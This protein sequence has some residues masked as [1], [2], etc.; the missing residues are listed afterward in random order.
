[1]K[2]LLII[3][4]AV[5]LIWLAPV[6][7]EAKTFTADGKYTAQ[8]PGG[9]KLQKEQNRFTDTM[10]LE[11]KGDAGVQLENEDIFV[12]TLSGDTDEDMIDS[13]LTTVDSM[14]DNVEEQ[15]RG[16]GKYIINNQTAP[17]LIVTYDQEFTN[18]LGLPADSQEWVAMVI[19]I[20]L[21]NG[22]FVVGQYRN[23]ADDFDD[24][25]PMAEKI[26]KSVEGLGNETKI[27]TE[28]DTFSETGTGTGTDFSKTKALCDTVT[29]QSGK[30]LCETLLN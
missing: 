4:P 12:E 25:L 24:D 22:D 16:T 1:M 10:T 11:C 19:A 20:K 18:F 3:V 13:L 15:E 6:T 27:E 2:S 23:T 14:W 26:F 29:T 7:A 21:G 30:D 9:C 28:T 5:L 8:Y 17:Y